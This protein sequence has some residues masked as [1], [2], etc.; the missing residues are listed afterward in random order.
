MKTSANILVVGASGQLGSA[1][2]KKLI[3][4]QKKVI[5]LVR[6]TAS[7]QHLSSYGVEV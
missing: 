6:P 2:V 7:Y 4:R 1:I 5:A 3:E